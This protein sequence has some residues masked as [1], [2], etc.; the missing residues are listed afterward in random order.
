MPGTLAGVLR[1]PGGRHFRGRASGTHAELVTAAAGSASRDLLGFRDST[2]RRTSRP[3]RSR[4][5]G[6]RWTTLPRGAP[7]RAAGGRW[8]G[9]PPAGPPGTAG[10][11][12]ARPPAATGSRRAEAERLRALRAAEATAIAARAWRH[13]EEDAGEVDGLG[14]AVVA[15]APGPAGT[16]WPSSSPGSARRPAASRTS[17]WPTS[18]RPTGP[19]SFAPPEFR[20]LHRGGRDV[21]TRV[22]K[23]HGQSLQT[24]VVSRARRGAQTVLAARAAG[25]PV[26]GG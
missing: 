26:P 9:R 15:A 21:A 19:H 7:G 25:P 16:T 17:P 23:P 20:D 14:A 1:A 10:T 12:A 6:T 11:T 24:P 22:T 13:L 5:T 4:K 18:T 2:G 8:P 3:G